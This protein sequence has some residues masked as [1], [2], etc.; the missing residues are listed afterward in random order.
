M[1]GSDRYLS[2]ERVDTTPILR[3]PWP[4]NDIFNGD[5]HDVPTMEWKEWGR[6]YLSSGCR[7]H[8]TGLL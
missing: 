7:P 6:I 4:I 5:V 3:T 8:H 2:R 1:N